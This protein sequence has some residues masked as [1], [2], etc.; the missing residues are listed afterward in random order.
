MKK[1]IV[2]ICIA[3]LFLQSCKPKEPLPLLLGTWGMIGTKTTGTSDWIIYPYD[4]K[5]GLT[6]EFKNKGEIITNSDYLPLGGGWCNSANSFTLSSSNTI[7]NLTFNKANCIPLVDP[8]FPDEA[9]IIS[10]TEKELIIERVGMYK[11]V[12]L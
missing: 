6:V 7:I 11:F 10:L 4:S 1:S 12:R 2:F 9:K 5:Y 3:I 8:R